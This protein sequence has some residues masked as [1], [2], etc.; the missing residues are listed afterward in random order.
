[1]GQLQRNRKQV[2]VRGLNRNRNRHLKELFKSAAISASTQ[3]GLFADY[4]AGLLKKGMKPAVARL[5]V[6]RKIAAMVL[7]VW[8]KGEHFEEAKLNTQAA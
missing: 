1:M 5:T 8:K 4:Y 3:P 7:A 2:T 6:A